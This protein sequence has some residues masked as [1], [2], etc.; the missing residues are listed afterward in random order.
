MR[1]G[2]FF[3]YLKKRGFMKNYGYNISY[4]YEQIMT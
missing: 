2:I 4:N 1:A 3:L